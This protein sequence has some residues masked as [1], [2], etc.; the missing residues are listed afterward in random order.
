[1]LAADGG[2]LFGALGFASRR[3]GGVAGRAKRQRPAGLRGPG[4]AHLNFTWRQRPS[5]VVEGLLYSDLM[6]LMNLTRNGLR[7]QRK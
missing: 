5:R 3:G 7:I 1:M 2:A 4:R 6:V